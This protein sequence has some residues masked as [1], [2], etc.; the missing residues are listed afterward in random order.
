MLYYVVENR[1]VGTIGNP[2]MLETVIYS[3]SKEDCARYEGHKRKEYEDNRHMVDCWTISKD[4]YEKQ[5]QVA[6]EYD[7][8]TEEE[9]KDFITVGGKK[10]IRKIWEKNN[11]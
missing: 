4:E 1:N 10:Y 8:L 7:E 6:K 2:E 9:R 5:Q 3:G 11:K